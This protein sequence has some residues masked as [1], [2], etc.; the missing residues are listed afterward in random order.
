M[1]IQFHPKR[2]TVLCANFDQG[3]RAPEMVK[4]RLCIVVSPP[5]HARA[6]LCTVVPL[7]TTDPDPL[8]SYHYKLDVP[9]VIPA[10][11]GNRSRWVKAD[12]VCAVGFHRLD[13]LRLDKGRDG[14]RR[15][16]TSVLSSV[17][18]NQIVSCILCSLGGPPLT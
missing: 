18:L 15:Y 3:F 1:A 8:M 5:I 7:S 17:H 10:P 4:R 6:G 9:F 14:K 2:G 12:M 13:L 11:W 16:Q